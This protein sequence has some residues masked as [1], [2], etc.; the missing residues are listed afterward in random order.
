MVG[1]DAV[2]LLARLF[3]VAGVQLRDG[4]VVVLL[5]R[6]EGQVVLLQLPLAGADVHPAAFLDLG[7]RG[8][9]QLFKGGQ[10]LLVLALLQQLHGGLVVLESRVRW[11][12]RSGRR[13]WQPGRELFCGLQPRI[14]PLASWFCHERA[15]LKRTVEPDCCR[16]ETVRLRNCAA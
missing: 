12:W 15:L 3:V 5:G 14:G 1:E 7:G 16:L 13:I 2:E 10:R 11:P 4:V 8:G 6:E 9:Q